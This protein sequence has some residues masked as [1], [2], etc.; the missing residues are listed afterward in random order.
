MQALSTVSITESCDQSTLQRI[1]LP[2]VQRQLDVQRVQQLVR[3]RLNRGSSF[4]FPPLVLAKIRDEPQLF[5]IDGQHRLEAV[6][7]LRMRHCVE[8]RISALTYT[9]DSKAQMVQLYADI[10]RGVRVPDYSAFSSEAREPAEQVAAQLKTTYT[11][12][13]STCPKARRP[14]LSFTLAQE[15]LAWL[16]SAVPDAGVAEVQEAIAA[17]NERLRTICTTHSPT[18][19]LPDSPTPTMIA[20]ADKHGCYLGLVRHD[21]ESSHGYEWVGRVA[22]SLGGPKLIE[23]RRSRRKAGV[24]KRVKILA[25]H[26][27]VGEDVA[28]THCPCC[29]TTVI[30]MA[31]FEAGHIRSEKAGGAAIVDNILPICAGCNRSM[32]TVHMAEFVSKHFPQNLAKFTDRSYTAAGSSRSWLSRLTG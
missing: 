12:I 31:D 32:G 21:S 23:I 1:L 14:F 7:I 8:E 27:W 10:N 15:A 20:K 22:E 6:K 26:R 30:S 4:P 3:Y 25:W 24:P 11:G 5:V 18:K 17:E 19:A 28:R 13:W 29:G 16:F 9:L 2:R